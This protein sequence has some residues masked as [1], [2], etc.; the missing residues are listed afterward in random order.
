MFSVLIP[1]WNNLAYLKLCVESIKK[2]SSYDHEILI[3]VNDGSDGTLE[4]VRSQGLKHSHTKKNI[5]VCLSVNYLAAQAKNDWIV[6][7]NDDMVCCPGWDTAFVNA[8]KSS[9]TDL[10]LFFSAMI[11]PYDT[12][13]P[14]VIVQDFGS[15]PS[16]FNE[17]KMLDNYMSVTKADV[18]GQGSQP[19]LVLRKWW[20]LVGGYSLEFSP[21]MSSDDDLLMKFWVI[22][23]RNFRMISL[24]RFYHFGSKSTHRIRRNRGGRTFVM[25]WGITQQEFH[26][27]FLSKSG[28]LAA[29][30]LEAKQSIQQF[31]RATLHGKLKRAAYGIFGDYPLEDLEAW[32]AGPAQ[33]IAADGSDV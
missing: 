13:H 10:A 2:F 1:T 29:E 14:C 8:I 21:G 30:M 3:H 31:P 20:H 33:H 24:S 4:W 18:E 16:D 22:G 17:F 32:D 26:S 7:V 28:R 9:K 15:T 23:C 19:T 25:K 12:G 27:R 11:Q 6:Y 5:G